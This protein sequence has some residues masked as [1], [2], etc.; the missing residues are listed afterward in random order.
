MNNRKI[1]E[2]KVENKVTYKSYAISPKKNFEN[3]NRNQK[4]LQG[5]SNYISHKKSDQDESSSNNK[6]STI[7][8]KSSNVQ[9]LVLEVDDSEVYQNKESKKRKEDNQQINKRKQ[10][11]R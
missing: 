5:Q 6:L 8:M 3:E 7:Y 11:F 9:N 2:S 1:V 4:T 10:I